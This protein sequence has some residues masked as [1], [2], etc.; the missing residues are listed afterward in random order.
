MP[1]IKSA[2]K[3]AGQS[4]VRRARNYNVRTALKKAIKDMGELTSAA[5]KTESE[6]ALS[7]AYKIID[8]AVKKNIMHKN[9][10]ARRKSSLSRMLAGIDKKAETSS[11]KPKA[12]AKKAKAKA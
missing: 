10:A 7:T 2:K 1:I 3:R 9:T 11:E 5:K 4:L 8:K 12:A 6:K